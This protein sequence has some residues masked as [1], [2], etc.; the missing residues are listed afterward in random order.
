MSNGG[1]RPATISRPVAERT[2]PRA[3]ILGTAD[4]LLA[5]SAEANPMLL[6][7][8]TGPLRIQRAPFGTEIGAKRQ[9]LSQKP[10][11]P[12]PKERRLVAT[13]EARAEP[14][15]ADRMG[16]SPRSGR[17]S[18]PPVPGLDFFFFL[19][20]VPLRSTRGYWLSLLRSWT[21]R[22]LRHSRQLCPTLIWRS[23]RSTP[24]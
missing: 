23:C 10:S 20:R 19:P 17:R 15:V 9:G 6:R 22:V 13:G 12:A 18:L 11:A 14:V 8:R 3:Q 16:T 21:S 2:H 1:T 5:S 7:S 24:F 4:G